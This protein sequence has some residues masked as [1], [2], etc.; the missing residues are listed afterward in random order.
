MD[1]AFYSY[2]S[3]LH[4]LIMRAVAPSDVPARLR[5]AYHLLHH[6]RARLIRNRPYR[7]FVIEDPRATGARERELRLDG[8]TKELQALFYPSSRSKS[9]GGARTGGASRGNQVDAEIARLVNEG[10]PPAAPNEY[11]AK[12]LQHLRDH[13]LQ[14]FA[15]QFIV[16]D[17]HVR[18]ATALDILCVDL[19][20]NDY[21]KNIVNVQLKTGFDRN[22]DAASGVFRS[23]FVADSPLTRMV[24]SH[25]NKHQLQALVEHLLLSRNYGIVVKETRVLV[26]AEDMHSSYALGPQIRA[27]AYD[28]Y[29][30][31][32]RRLRA[33]AEDPSYALRMRHAA[34]QEDHYAEQ[35]RRTFGH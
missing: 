32:Q 7:G 23:P 10:T 11:T 20:C 8:L 14:P 34:E 29:T 5:C 30:N 27:L 26:I 3:A 2:F 25:R 12:T 9:T 1:D 19:A 17:E 33:R 13:G 35:A 24:D 16:F 15:A 4:A 6:V 18:L 28:I 21:A 31:L 22:Y